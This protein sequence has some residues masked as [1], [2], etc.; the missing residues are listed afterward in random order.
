[1]DPTGFKKLSDKEIAQVSEQPSLLSTQENGIRTACA[2]P[3]EL[4]TD[5]GLSTDGKSFEIKLAASN[6]IFGK[7]AAGSPF[8]VYAPVK[9]SDGGKAEVSRNW[10]F[11][12]TAGDQLTY[13]WPLSAFENN[14]YHLRV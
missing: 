9:F 13:N 4:Y 14:R 7:N 8:T 11:A 1:E 3:Y 6:E 2:L 5:G 10:S 12:V